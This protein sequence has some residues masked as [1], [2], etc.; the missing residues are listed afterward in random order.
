MC[1]ITISAFVRADNKI[2]KR[3]V[4]VDGILVAYIR[5][6]LAGRETKEME[7]VLL[8]HKASLGAYLSLE[9]SGSVGRLR[10]GSENKRFVAGL[11]VAEGSDMNRRGRMR[12]IRQVEESRRGYYNGMDGRER[13]DR[14]R[15]EQYWER[16]GEK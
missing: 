7:E 14:E 9:E 16:E 11:A 2:I 15:R 13:E 8:L 1:S 3:V 12:L 4:V 5:T 10:E 6:Y